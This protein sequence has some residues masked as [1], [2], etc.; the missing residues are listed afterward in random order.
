MTLPCPTC[1]K[2]CD[3]PTI[4]KL[5]ELQIATAAQAEKKRSS[6]PIWL[7]LVAAFS[8]IVGLC[9]LI[10]CASLGWERYRFTSELSKAGVNIQHSEKEYLDEMRRFAS[11]SQPAD[12]WDYWNLMAEEGIQTPTTPEFFRIQRYLEYKL[13]WIYG[14][15]TVALSG[16]G[17]FGVLAL[18][19]QRSRR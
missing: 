12:T 7:G 6:Q 14:S 17:L 10:Y 18:V 3:V 11:Q 15:L 13:P 16:L 19:L 2:K 4:R 8:L 5:A 9:A 1:G